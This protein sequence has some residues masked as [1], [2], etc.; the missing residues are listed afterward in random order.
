MDA[1]NPT[2]CT[3]DTVPILTVQRGW[4]RPLDGDHNGTARCDMGA[5]ETGWDIFLP[6][7]MRNWP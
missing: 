4:P 5:V 6:L 7:G 1:G 2:G 3:L